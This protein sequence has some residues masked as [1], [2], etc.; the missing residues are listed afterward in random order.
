MLGWS[1]PPTSQPVSWPWRCSSD[2]GQPARIQSD[3]GGR[4]VKK[5]TSE[6]VLAIQC[7]RCCEGEPKVRGAEAAPPVHDGVGFPEGITTPE[8]SDGGLHSGI[9]KI[10]ACGPGKRLAVLLV[11]RAIVLRRLPKHEAFF[12]YSCLRKN[13]KGVGFINKHLELL[14]F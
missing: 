8:H 6:E 1:L 11:F 10:W 12:L 7:D 13:I 3:T 9:R 4:Q 5:K 14:F 2:Q